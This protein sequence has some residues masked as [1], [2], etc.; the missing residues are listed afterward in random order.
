M[1]KERERLVFSY[2][3]EGVHDRLFEVLLP[4]LKHFA[5]DF[6]L[7]FDVFSTYFD[8]PLSP[9]KF[10]FLWYFK[11]QVSNLMTFSVQTYLF[12]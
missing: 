11:R 9:H 2:T 4:L 12:I 3:K 10:L 5:L 6:T 1:D 8:A 7:R